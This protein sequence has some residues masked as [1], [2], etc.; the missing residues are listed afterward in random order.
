MSH[1]SLPAFSLRRPVTVVMATI[2]MLCLGV[3]A[4]NRMPLNFLPRVDRPFIGVFIAYP[5]AS[6]AQVEQQIAIPAE[7]ELRTIPGVRRIRSTSTSNGCDIGLLF[8]LDTD[9]SIATADVRDRLERLKLILP[10]EAD[11]MLIQRFSSGSIPVLA[12]GMFRDGDQDQFVHMM[13][14]VVQPRLSR[15][16]GVANVEILS[17]IQ[18]REVLIE[19]DQHTLQS[20]NLNIA[21]VVQVIRESSISVSLGTLQDGTQKVYA[22]L[23]GEYRKLDDIASMVVTPNGMRLRDIAQVSY[24][25]RE[26]QQ[27]VALDGAGGAVVLVI[28][29][30]EANTVSTCRNVHR[31]LEAI[32]REPAFQ[33]TTHH[34]FFDQSDL[35][36]RALRNLFYQGIYGSIMAISV[37]FFFLHKIIPTLIVSLSIPASLM[38]AIVFMFF[39]GMSLNIV[40]MVS[41]IVAVGMLVD[42]AIVVT[43]NIIRRRQ[44]G[45]PIREAA[46]DGAREVGLAIVAS[47]AT[48]A[49]VFL[50]MYFIEVGRMSVFMEQLGGPLVVSLAGSLL[51]ALTVVPL[52]MS[53]LKIT[54]AGNI[55]EAIAKGFLF[56]ESTRNLSTRAPEP[57]ESSTSPG[58]LRTCV[59]V[60]G[61]L[62]PI[63]WVIDG[64]TVLLAWTLR[65]RLVFL[66]ILGG[67]IYLTWLIPMQAVG[68]RDM[69][70]LDTREIRID[71]ALDQNYDMPRIAELFSN[72]ETNINLLRQE[73]GIKKILTL[74]GLNNG[75]LEV[76]LYTE[77]D[78]PRWKYPPYTTEEAMF[79]L[80]QRLPERVPGAELKFS[81]ADAGR[82][83]EGEGEIT[84][85][86]RGDNA[87][88][89]EGYAEQ[90]RQILKHHPLFTDATTNIEKSSQ[91]I[92]LRIDDPL[93]K[94]A[95]ISPLIVAQTVDAA[96]RG[97]RLPFMKQGTREIPVWA[98]FREEDRKS[99]ANLDNV[100][101]PGITGQLIPLQRVAEYRKAPSPAAIRRING[102]NVVLISAKLNTKNMS[103]A[104]MAIESSVD[105][106]DL[107]PGY[108]VD[109]GEQFLDLEEGFL[110]FFSSLIM[111]IIL[112]YIV[113]AALF[114]SLLLPL[115]IMTTVPLALGGGVW[116]MWYMGNQFDQITLIGC[117]L[118]VGVIVNNGIV[119]VDYINQRYRETGDRFAAV[120]NSGRDRFRP[121]MMT[122]LTTILGLVPLAMAKTG[123]AS[124]FAGLGQALTGGIT[125]GTMLTLLVVPVFYTIADDARNWTVDFLG[126]LAKL[127]TPKTD[128]ATA[129]S[130]VADGSS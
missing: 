79:I 21:Q 121:V 85:S 98:Q 28:K 124:T 1:F 71:V 69:P 44:L 117:I 129:S 95:G 40:T 18:P 45:E 12:F 19:F 108:S 96:L 62:H 32:L 3:I 14:T 104:K 43:E 99:Q 72:L 37:L 97:A 126:S 6:P 68:M 110:N 26:E 119:I 128:T 114:E 78:D 16:E 2:S 67:L 107:P 30:S 4:W 77:D 57:I 65:R 86:L 42:N 13:R 92:Q 127:R 88:M 31:E 58:L 10:A 47:T 80:S 48:T 36:L 94:A 106:L 102:K 35:I 39:T 56:R 50:P 34:V 8:T 24:R 22:R 109:I 70:K 52:V 116:M 113:M 9:M 82:Q 51:V 17:P 66:L 125:V 59:H 90:L 100:T 118:M 76:Y 63:Q 87:A 53:R 73:L 74:Y 23:S 7:G 20:M 5:G 89:L 33:N 29:E 15:L 120:V 101:V 38:I 84:L 75:F 123:G 105:A 83:E 25:S 91:E 55:F 61:A 46:V 81:M 111:A 64:Y 93:A 115:S 60:L 112:V 103:A 11:K 49:V 54:R 130:P 27:Y 122:A 41:M